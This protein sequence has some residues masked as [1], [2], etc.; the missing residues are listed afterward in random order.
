MSFNVHIIPYK[1]QARCSIDELAAEQAA[2]DRYSRVYGGVSFARKDDSAGDDGKRA[3]RNAIAALLTLD[4]MPGC[5]SLLTM[6]GID[7]HFE[8]KLLKLR[9]PNW[10]HEP[11]TQTLRL[12][13]VENDRLV[14]YSATTRMPGKHTLMR[15]L[16]RPGYAERS[17][18]NGIIDRYE[19]ANVDDLMQSGETFDFAWLD[20]TGPLS[21][22]RMAI[23]EA[24][25]RSRVR[26]T[27]VVTSLKA[28][29]NRET[30]DTIARHGGPMD[31]MRRR[32]PGVELH[33]L[34]Y[35]DTSPMIQFAVRKE[36]PCCGAARS[37]LVE[38][39]AQKAKQ[40]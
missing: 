4:A 30:S 28:R 1:A 22:K 11:M 16:D 38:V 3:A 27:L 12:T 40:P 10:R 23:I 13:C 8:G 9:E 26:H 32:L 6:P 34:D 15:V 33:A 2:K 18:G 17:M 25:W 31:W 7:W 21:V 29:W 14:Y 20:Y 39:D 36:Y 19:F 24:F 5:I 35:N 37:L